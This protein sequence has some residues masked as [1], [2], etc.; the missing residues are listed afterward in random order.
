VRASTRSSARR[1]AQALLIAC[2]TCAVP[3]PAAA[4]TGLQNAGL[5]L[6]AG[7]DGMPDCWQRG[8]Y[9]INASTFARVAGAHGGGTAEEVRI[10]A[11]ASGDR[12]LLSAQDGGTC[13]PAVEPGSAY[14]LQAWYRGDAPTR[15]VVYLRT[16]TGGWSYWTSGPALPASSG[17]ALATWTTPAVPSGRVAIS[18]GLNLTRV[19]TLVTDDYA[20]T[21]AAAPAAPA[22]AAPCGR[23][24]GWTP[25]QVDQGGGR[26]LYTP[27]ADA[28]AAACVTDAPETVPAN[29]AANA[30]VPGDTELA[31]FRAALSPAGRTPEQEAWYPRYVTGRPGLANPSTDE[32]I[33][34]AAHKWG[35]PEDWLRAQYVQESGWRQAAMGDLGTEPA[36]WL[37]RFPAFSCPTAA[38]CYES[39][40]IS[41]LKWRPDG[42][43]GAGTEPLRWRSTAFNI[44]Y[45]A[46]MIRFEYDN[47]YGKRSAWGDASYRPFDPW[48]AL[49]AWY[50]S[51]PYGNAAQLGYID[52]VKAHLTARDWPG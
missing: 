37:P 32:L 9:G 23:Q 22:V 45:Q 50:S 4:A 18:F 3:P 2:I 40:G 35:I 7:G 44:D 33:Q 14:R 52:R 27:L 46:S 21:A 48:L 51:Y 28:A 49:G 26:H 36:A 13:A 42:S 34:W 38:Q 10:T 12:K 20:L 8:G 11:L 30:Y 6:D 24:A 16:A 17:W 41:Q 31:A 25:P 47:P 19:G 43:R 15:F 29:L 1:F 39:L 5:E